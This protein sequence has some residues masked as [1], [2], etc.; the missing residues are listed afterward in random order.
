MNELLEAI[1]GS[2]GIPWEKLED[3]YAGVAYDLEEL[4]AQGKIY[5]VANKDLLKKENSDGIFRQ[6][7]SERELN[8]ILENQKSEGLA[9][10]CKTGFVYFPCDLELDRSNG[11]DEDLKELW[12]DVTTPDK[13]ELDRQLFARQLI[14][15]EEYQFGDS[16][17][18][19]LPARAGAKKKRKMSSF[20]NRRTN[21]TNT[22]LLGQYD[23]FKKK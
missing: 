17:D 15:A 19:V 23:W 4:I 14:S 18:M 22:H 20:K 2:C 16:H 9:K 13:A 7:A 21:L 8:G 3:A 1:Q 6:D 5:S 11:V 10:F 12:F